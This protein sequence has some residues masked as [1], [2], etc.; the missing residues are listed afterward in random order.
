MASWTFN[1]KFPYDIQFT[2]RSLIFA[3]GEDGNLKLLTQGPAPKRFVS[4]YGQVSYLTTNSFTS[5]GA[6]SGLNPY[7]GP[8]HRAAKT[9]QGILIGHL[10]SSH[11]LE[12]R[13][14]LHRHRPLIKTQ[15]MTTLRSG[16]V[17]VGTP[18]MRVTLSS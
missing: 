5:G 12:H 10:S 16:K 3:A 9:I 14:L 11:Q 4:V 17:P 18:L 6:C 15:L 7:V 1:I 8:Y 2:F 13:A